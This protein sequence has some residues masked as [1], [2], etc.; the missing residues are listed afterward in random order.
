MGFLFMV[1][2]FADMFGE[3]MDICVPAMFERWQIKDE[4]M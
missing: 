4:E 1:T 2:V 3:R